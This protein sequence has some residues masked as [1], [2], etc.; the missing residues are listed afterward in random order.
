MYLIRSYLQERNCLSGF[1]IV[2]VMNFL[3]ILHFEFFMKFSG[4]QCQMSQGPHGPIFIP[5][6]YIVATLSYVRV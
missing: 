4:F 6:L 1:N 3:N 5:V 2:K